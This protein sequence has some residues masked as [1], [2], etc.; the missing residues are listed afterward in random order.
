L[1][2]AAGALPPVSNS[3]TKRKVTDAAPGVVFGVSVEQQP[4]CTT[5]NDTFANDAYLGSYGGHS[6]TNA[7]TP[8]KFFL[9]TQVGGG[10]KS[11]ASS[12]ATDKIELSPPRS[13]V[14]FDSWAP[15]FE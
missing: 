8:G 13:T 7:V 11:N 12:V 5:A 2:G 15:I 9:V 14:V 4:S 6:A 3:S 1:S 10:D